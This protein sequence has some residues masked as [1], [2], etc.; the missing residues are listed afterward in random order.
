MLLL[1][2]LL[3]TPADSQANALL[4]LTRDVSNLNSSQVEQ[5]VSQLEDLLSGPTVSLELGNTSVHIVSNLLDASP[6]VLATTS[7]RLLMN[8]S[9][10]QLHI[11]WC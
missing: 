1:L 9:D 6:E 5:L 3:S 2:L 11:V 4:D 8:S 10:I 7:N